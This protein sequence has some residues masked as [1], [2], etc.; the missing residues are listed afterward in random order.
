MHHNDEQAQDFTP[1]EP[2]APHPANDLDES[3]FALDPSQRVHLVHEDDWFG[4]ALE[5]SE[6]NEEDAE[7]LWT[8]PEDLRV[9]DIVLT[10]VGGAHPFIICIERVHEVGEV[11]CMSPQSVLSTPMLLG[12]L[13][14]AVGMELSGDDSFE[15]AAARELLGT[16]KV[17]LE[18]PQPIIVE[19]PECGGRSDDSA[20]SY[21]MATRILDHDAPDKPQACAGCGTESGRLQP[22]LPTEITPGQTL[23]L[24]DLVN[25]MEL[26]CPTCHEFFHGSS[27]DLL[28]RLRRPTCPECGASN[29]QE[30]LWGMPAFPTDEE[31][32]VIAG[33]AFPEWPWPQWLCRECDCS[34]AVTPTR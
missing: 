5:L 8:L 29:P 3:L 14:K 22:H 30:Y 6:V 28:K 7:F 13:G 11:A 24:H 17:L 32:Y 21:V 9:G 10:A 20:W 26:F 16:F 12:R 19:V 15:G 34:Y 33:C 25:R 31:N 1:D 18:D 4:A 27:V 23:E 2:G